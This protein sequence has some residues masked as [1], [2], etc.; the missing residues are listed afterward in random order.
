[1]GGGGGGG[2]CGPGEDALGGVGT[3][4][5]DAN[6]PRPDACICM[7]GSP[8]PFRLFLLDMAARGG[9]E[10]ITSPLG[11]WMTVHRRSKDD[12]RLTGLDVT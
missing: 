6:M 7:G 10:R 5:A 1:M 11:R 12:A 2:F 3:A 9:G 8:R 4:V